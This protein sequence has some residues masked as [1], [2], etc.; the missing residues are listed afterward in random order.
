MGY[1]TLKIGFGGGCHWCTEAV[2]QSLKGVE[3]VEQG[4]ISTKNFPEKF[5]EAVI[6]HYEEK[7]I[8]LEDLIQIHLETHNSNSDH[9][10]RDK[11]L[12]AI[13][14][15]NNDQFVASENILNKLSSQGSN[16]ITK[17]YEF[18]N[19]RSSRD[20]ILNYYKKGPDKPFCRTYIR[21][22]LDHIQDNYSDYFNKI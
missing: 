16:F 20:E 19:F 3:F 4:Y 15:F 5:Y 13:Y 9:S 6:V 7:K 2:F 17:V 8:S 11:Y 10:M 21:P 1:C 22:K 14:S 18:G 12:S